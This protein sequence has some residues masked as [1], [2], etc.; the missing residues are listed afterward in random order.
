M[1]LEGLLRSGDSGSLAARVAAAL[2]FCVQGAT[3]P[4]ATPGPDPS[5]DAQAGAAA[6]LAGPR[7]AL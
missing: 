3:D 2:G 7:T 4:G 5:P 1:Q 6:G